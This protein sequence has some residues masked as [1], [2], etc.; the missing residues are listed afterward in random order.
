MLGRLQD[1]QA[2]GTG[3]SI[4]N[5]ESR[6]GRFLAWSNASGMVL[7]IKYCEEEGQSRDQEFRTQNI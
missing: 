4:N 3:W 7:D 6:D 5:L 2:P 1:R